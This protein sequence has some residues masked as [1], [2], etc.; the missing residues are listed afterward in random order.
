[1]RVLFS[2]LMLVLSLNLFS[3][4]KEITDKPKSL[5]KTQAQRA[6]EK[7]QKAPITS[8]KIYSIERDTIILDTTLSIKKDYELNFL[9]KDLFGLM[10]F[11]NEGQ[12]YTTLDFGLTNF[13]PFPEFGFK[14]KHMNYIEANDINYYSVATPLTELYYKSVMEQ[15]QNV[16]ALITLNTSK[17]LNFSIA[18]K[19]LRSIGKYINIKNE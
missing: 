19:G 12:T 14:A 18:F 17:N 5:I 11:P 13:S 7:A 16:D 1:M 9:R 2:I 10:P 4:E 6:K 8:Y 3:Q 15:G